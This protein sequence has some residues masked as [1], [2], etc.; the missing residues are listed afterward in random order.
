MKAQILKTISFVM[1]CIFISNVDAQDQY[2]PYDNFPGL[3][4]SYKPAY[5]NDYPAF[6]KMLYQ[7]PVNYFDIKREFELYESSHK[8]IKSPEIRYYKIW[9]RAIAPFVKDDGSI[10]LPDLDKYYK[11]LNLSQLNVENITGS[12][13]N[14]DWTFLGPKETFWLN[15]SGSPQIPL[16]CPWQVNVYSFDIAPTDI[17]V[18]WINFYPV[19]LKQSTGR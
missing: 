9:Q 15:E 8:G 3:I 19:S 17:R 12:K 7:Y 5:Q 13:S 4:K 2:T 1:V 11:R 14:S 18:V 6:A 10:I 16:A